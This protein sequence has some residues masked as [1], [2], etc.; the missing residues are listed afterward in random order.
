MIRIGIIGCGRILA[1]HLRGFR[2][3]REAGVD[4]FRITALCARKIEDAQSYVQ[5]GQ[6]PPQRSAVSN[7]PGDVLAIDDEYLSDFQNDVDVVL[8]DDFREMITTG[9]IDAVNDY[10]LHG[11]HHVIAELSAA[12][13]KHL[14]T[15]KPISVTIGGARSMCETYDAKGLTLGVFENWRYAPDSIRMLALLKAGIIG[16]P[17]IIHSGAIGA[18][19]APD[20]IVAET[21]WRHRR[22]QAGGITL[23]MGVRQFDLVRAVG[24]EV[25]SIDGR[26]HTI[27]PVRRTRDAAGN[28]TARVECDADDTYFATF[29]TASGTIGSM[30]AS[31]AGHAAPTICGPG[32]VI[33]TTNGQLRGNVFTSDSRQQSTLSELYDQHFTPEQRDEDFHSLDDSFALTQYDWLNAV[34]SNASPLVDGWEGLRD[35]ACAWAV[36]ESSKAGRR[37]TLDEILSGELATAQREIAPHFGLES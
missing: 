36:L 15:Q 3:L 25:I 2:L 7:I 24:G 26:A 18:W 10:T 35:L 6:G 28:E 29:E 13:G 33:Y 9:P 19:W 27:E 37:V 1:A 5:R 31:W 23:D 17:Q 20:Q 22:E 12:N 16:T 21:P 8:Y 34:R 4:D 14:L 30:H 11:L 32:P